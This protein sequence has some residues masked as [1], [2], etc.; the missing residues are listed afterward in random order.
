MKRHRILIAL[1]LAIFCLGSIFA[2]SHGEGMVRALLGAYL[3][4]YGVHYR[5]FDVHGADVNLFENNKSG[6]E[7]VV[8]LHGLGGDALYT[9]FNLLPDLAAAHHVIAI[10]LSYR[11]FQDLDAHSYSQ[12]DELKNIIAVLDDEGISIAA[13]SGLTAALGWWGGS[14]ARYPEPVDRLSQSL[15][16]CRAKRLLTQP[17]SLREVDARGFYDRIFFKP[18]PI[19][20]HLKRIRESRPTTRTCGRWNDLPSVMS[21]SSSMRSSG[22]PCA[23]CLGKRGPTTAR[24]SGEC[25]GQGLPGCQVLLLADCGHAVVWIIRAIVESLQR[26]CLGALSIPVQAPGRKR[27]IF[28]VGAAQKRHSSAFVASLT[29]LR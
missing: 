16:R 15:P 7:T 24:A 13:S 28:L 9:W 22:Q 10:D 12:E 2:I 11:R 1:I 5:Q 19:P 21:P 27:I 14:R 26:S 20:L 8:L 3:R 17:T 18:P 25:S 29:I 23:H 6:L 4:M